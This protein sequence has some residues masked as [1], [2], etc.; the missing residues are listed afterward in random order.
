[1]FSSRSFMISGLTFKSLIHFE[2]LFVWCEKIVQFDSSA[3]SWP[4]FPTSF[5]EKAF[6]SLMD[7]LA[8]FVV[9]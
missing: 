8:S 9:N 6:F 1:M 5:T 2:F 7:I 3:C 4:I